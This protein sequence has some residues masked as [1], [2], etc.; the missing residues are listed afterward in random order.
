MTDPSPKLEQRVRASF[1]AK[2]PERLF[3]GC[4]VAEVNDALVVRIY[5][6]DARFPNLRPRPYQVFRFDRDSDTLSELSDK[7]AAPFVIPNY[8]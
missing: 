5:N 6:N 4:K 7:D 8:K 1:L 3:R 2:Y